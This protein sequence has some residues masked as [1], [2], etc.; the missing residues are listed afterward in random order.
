M[1]VD[2]GW[3]VVDVGWVAGSTSKDDDDPAIAGSVLVMLLRMLLALIATLRLLLLF[4]LP[5]LAKGNEEAFADRRPRRELFVDD[6]DV[7]SR[8]SDVLSRPLLEA[9]VSFRPVAAAAT[10]WWWCRCLFRL[11]WP[12]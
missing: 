1:V 3:V 9:S 8:P 12:P 4:C 7:L 10:W 6:S 11:F 5:D 2:V